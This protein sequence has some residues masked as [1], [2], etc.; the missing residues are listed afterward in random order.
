MSVYYGWVTTPDG[1]QPYY[2]H[3]AD[4][5]ELLPAAGLFEFSKDTTDQW[6]MTFTV[7]T[8][9]GV[10]AAGEVHD[11]MPVF[12]DRTAGNR[13]SPRVIWARANGTTCCTCSTTRH[14]ASPAA[15]SRGRSPRRSTTRAPQIRPTATSSHPSMCEHEPSPAGSNAARR[16]GSIRGLPVVP[17]STRLVT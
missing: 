14:S 2:L 13:G 8:R 6:Q 9:T 11:R 12:L 16:I 4:E 1:K 10:D 17:W 5:N 15:C 3:S 7:L